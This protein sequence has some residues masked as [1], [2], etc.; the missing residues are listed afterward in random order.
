MAFDLLSGETT[1]TSWSRGDVVLDVAVSRAKKLPWLKIFIGTGIAA[2]AIMLLSSD[3]KKASPRREI[4][5]WMKETQELPR[6]SMSQVVFE[7]RK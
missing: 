6:E 7:K 2:G 4:P 5:H 3:E 1:K